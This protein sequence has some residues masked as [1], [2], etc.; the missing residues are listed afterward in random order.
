MASIRSQIL[1]RLKTNLDGAGK[2][3]GVTVELLR[4]SNLEGV[5]LPSI[6]IRITGEDVSLARPDNDR[7]PVVDRSLRVVFECRAEAAEGQTI[8]DAI[9]ALTNWVTKAVQTDPR[10]GGLA[11]GSREN[12]TEWQGEET[13]DGTYA[14]AVVTFTIRYQTKTNDQEAKA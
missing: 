8:E 11:I 2:P 7:C 3:A 10:L 9:D 5:Y 4:L 12:S 14:L 1:D 13:A 6:I